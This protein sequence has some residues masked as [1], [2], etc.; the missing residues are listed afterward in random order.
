MWLVTDDVPVH[1]VYL[2][3]TK[4]TTTKGNGARNRETT[5]CCCFAAPCIFYSVS[6]A[7]LHSLL[8]RYMLSFAQPTT[9][10]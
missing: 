5:C 1:P 9:F 8:S 7:P 4:K 6:L 3:M 10:H 2:W